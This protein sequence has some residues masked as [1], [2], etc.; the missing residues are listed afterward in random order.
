VSFG[1][2]AAERD[3]LRAAIAMAAGEERAGVRW[4]GPVFD[5]EVDFHGRGDQPLRDPIMR[6]IRPR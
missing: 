3:R 2:P 4:V 1:L 5:V 6:G